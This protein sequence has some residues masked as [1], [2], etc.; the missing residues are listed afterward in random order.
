VAQITDLF[1]HLTVGRNVG[2]GLRYARLTA[3]EREARLARYLE[4]FGLEEME[5]RPAS[6]LSGGES[7]KVAMARSLIVQ[8]R[9]LLLDEPLGMLDHNERRDMVRVLRMVHEELQTTTIHVTHDRQEA[10]SVAQRCAVMNAGRILETGTVAE[11]FR[12]PASRLVAEFLVGVNIFRADFAEGKARTSWGSVPLEARPGF[13]QGFVLIRPEQMSIVEEKAGHKISGKVLALRD[14]GEHVEV[15][16]VLGGSE[17]LTVHCSV[18]E[19]SKLAMGQEIHLDWPDSA[20]RA[21]ED[22]G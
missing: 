19:A 9:L 18:E 7:K 21:L 1:P 6:A 11:L 14:L 20:V 13:A 15:E 5:D 2:F 3:D 4:M 16:V 17:T 10:W 12:E 22:K 8:P